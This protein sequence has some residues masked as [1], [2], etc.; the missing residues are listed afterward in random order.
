[1]P[2]EAQK[3]DRIMEKFAERYYQTNQDTGTFASAGKFH[4]YYYFIV[5]YCIIINYLFY[6]LES[7]YILAFAIVLLATDLHSSQIKK[8]MTKEEWVK[9][10]RG[11]NAKQNFDEAYLLGMYPHF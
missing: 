10:N 6:L 9:M 8:H 7:A 2:G 3:I 4:F 5:W 1:M 11:N